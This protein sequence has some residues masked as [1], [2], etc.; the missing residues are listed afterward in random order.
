MSLKHRCAKHGL[1]WG[2]TADAQEMKILIKD[3]FVQ[4]M[5]NDFRTLDGWDAFV[6]KYKWSKLTSKGENKEAVALDVRG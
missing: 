3:Y 1:R 4:L 5:E 6:G 2:N